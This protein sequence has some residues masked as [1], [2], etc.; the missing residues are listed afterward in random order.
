M[1]QLAGRK[2][3]GGNAIRAKKKQIEH[4]LYH[5][6]VHWLCMGWLEEPGRT[7]TEVT[8]KRGNS[9]ALCIHQK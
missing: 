7:M 1:N 8:P 2:T 6:E 3:G 4:F 9:S 5:A